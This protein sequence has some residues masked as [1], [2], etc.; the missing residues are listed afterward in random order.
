MPK[1]ESRTQARGGISPLASATSR[2]A[3]PW[4]TAR[5]YREGRHATIITVMR[6]TD[7]TRLVGAKDRN[8]RLTA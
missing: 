4:K 8:I 2:N 7:R 5:D 1:D 3:H 6:I